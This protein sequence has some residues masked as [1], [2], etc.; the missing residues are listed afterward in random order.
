MLCTLRLTRIA[1]PASLLLATARALSSDGEAFCIAQDGCD[2]ATGSLQASALLQRDSL[3]K[4]ASAAGREE[5]EAMQDAVLEDFVTDD[6]D[7][8][9][10]VSDPSDMS[11]LS[12]GEARRCATTD[13]QAC[14]FGRDAR[15]EGGHCIQ[16]YAYGAYGW[17]YTS[18]GWGNCNEYCPLGG[19]ESMLDVKL[20]RV[21][22]KMRDLKKEVDTMP[23]KCC[24]KK[25]GKTAR[26]TAP[27]SE[28]KSLL[29]K[30]DKKT[31][32]ALLAMEPAM[33]FISLLRKRGLQRKA[34]K[35]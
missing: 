25:A 7:P 17:C 8:D 30:G 14:I 19:Q 35:P 11:A 23:A 24:G 10:A 5:G 16:D 12:T 27:K 18:S 31:A 4:E 6:E 1:L 32:P 20:S 26:K 2:E 9:E 22:R 13:G 15:D 34:G 33:E 28:G 21:E 29:A 3:R